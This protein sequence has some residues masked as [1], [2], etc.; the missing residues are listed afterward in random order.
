MF[1]HGCCPLVSQL[2]C[3]LSRLWL[4]LHL[5]Q[6]F[7]GGV[8]VAVV[9]HFAEVTLLWCQH[10]VNLRDDRHRAFMTDDLTMGIRYFTMNVYIYSYR[11][12]LDQLN[13]FFKIITFKKKN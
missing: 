3:A 5:L 8:F 6:I 2:S 9:L 10:G 1:P 4:D 12:R 13:I 11:I 7:V